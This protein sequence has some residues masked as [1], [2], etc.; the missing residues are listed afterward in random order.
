MRKGFSESNS[1]GSEGLLIASGSDIKEGRVTD[2]YF[3]FTE[4]ILKSKG[5]NTKVVMEFYARSLPEGDWGIVSGIYEAVKLLRGM[6]LDVRAMEE[7]TVFLADKN[8]AV[9]EP[10]LQVEGPYVEFARYENPILGFLCTMSGVATRAARL[11]MAA[12]DRTL[13]SFGSRRVHPALAPAVEWSAFIGGV[14]GVSNVLG[15][16]MIGEKAVGTMPHSLIL[17]LG[18]QRIAWK[19]FDEVLP[20]SVPRIALIDTLFDEKTEAIMAAD[21]LGERL[22]GVRI[23]TPGSRRG[24]IR[25]IVEEVRWELNMR[26]RHDVKIYVS[27]GLGE[28]DIAGLSDIADGFGVGTYLS[29][30]PSVDFSGKLVEIVSEDGTRIPRAKR[31]DISGRKQVYRDWGAMQDIVQPSDS[32]APKGYEPLLSDVLK[33]GK[34]VRDLLEPREI[35]ERTKRNLQ[36]LSALRPTLRWNVPKTS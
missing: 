13:L 18:D 11:R 9:Y 10:V 31:G 21:L 5:V 25:K 1:P 32:E 12:K 29:D 8:E 15:A 19:S 14:D 20:A 26:G 30:A 36:R 24:N 35:R 4:Q 17:V 33:N 28:A 7:G 6:R 27:G 16:E 3:L 2:A 23:D 22:T 34:L